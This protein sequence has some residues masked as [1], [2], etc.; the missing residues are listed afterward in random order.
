VGKE[1]LKKVLYSLAIKLPKERRDKVAKSSVELIREL[2]PYTTG[3]IM[4][5]LV[6]R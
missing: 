1:L 2:V 3:R 6:Q 4:E 5:T